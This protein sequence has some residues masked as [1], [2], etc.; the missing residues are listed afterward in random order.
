M[1]SIS[2]LDKSLVTAIQQKIDNKTKPKGALGQLESLALQ[3]AC[4]QKNE[5]ITFSLPTMLIFAADHGI[6]EEGVSIAPP[7]VTQQ[8]VANFLAG[9]AAI[10]CFCRLHHMDLKVINAGMLRSIDNDKLIDLSLGSGTNNFSVRPAMSLDQVNQGFLF[11]QQMLESLYK[12]GCNLIALGEMGIG[13]TSSASAIMAAALNCSVEQCVGYGTGID[14]KTLNR[15]RQLIQQALELHQS[16]LTDPVNILAYLGGFEIVQMTGVML[17]AAQRQMTILVDGFIA[18]VAALMATQIH[19]G[20]RDYMVFCHQSKEQ[21]HQLLLQHLQAEPL[22][23]LG[24]GLGEGTGAALAF[25][26]LQA[27]AAFYND[28]ASFEVAGVDNVI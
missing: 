25:P 7:A 5:Q 1:Y 24:M 15:K 9:G 18:S 4:I 27:A 20:C 2:P 13:N 8:M 21:G 6:A 11:A 19:P 3:L 10:N 28:M 23:R 16:K 26:L 22:L 14:D 17:A 12:Q